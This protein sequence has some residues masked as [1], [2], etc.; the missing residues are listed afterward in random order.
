MPDV[1]VLAEA[2]AVIGGQ[3][4][5][6][7]IAQSELVDPFEQLPDIVVRVA[8]LGIVAL[9]SARSSRRRGSRRLGGISRI[10]SGEANFSLRW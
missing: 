10:S 5:N 4:H 1:A 9:E 6:R 3:R 7:V 2:F 8:D